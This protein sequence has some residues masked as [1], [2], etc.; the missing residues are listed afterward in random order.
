MAAPIVAG[1]T[2]LVKARFP[3]RF[4]APHF[5]LEHVKET[6]VDKRFPETP[7]WTD[8]IRLHRVD[9]LCSVTDNAACPIPP[10]I[11]EKFDPIDLQTE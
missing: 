8:E 3:T 6:S 4:T 9:A 11:P 10:M 1:V 2:A 5:L 7:P